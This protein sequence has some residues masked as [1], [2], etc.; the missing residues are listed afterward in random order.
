MFITTEN[1]WAIFGNCVIYFCF[2]YFRRT[3]FAWNWRLSS[4]SSI[5][6]KVL[7]DSYISFKTGFRILPHNR[8]NVKLRL[9]IVIGS[10]TAA[11]RG[12]DSIIWKMH[13]WNN[14]SIFFGV[15]CTEQVNHWSNNGRF[16]NPRWLQLTISRTT[17]KWQ[18][19]FMALQVH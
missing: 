19:R 10:L 18:L 9:Q 13:D 17:R 16:N 3:A 6:S 5:F 14:A 8:K 1:L 4:L 2:L 11:N 15:C 12:W 7:A